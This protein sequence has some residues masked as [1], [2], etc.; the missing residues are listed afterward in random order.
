MAEAAVNQNKE[1]DVF[2]GSS[3]MAHLCRAVDWSAT[4]LGPVE[5]WPEALRTVVRT[6]LE[7]PFPTNLWCGPD[8]LLIYN[9]GYRRVLGAKHPRALGRAGAEVWREIWPDIQPMFDSVRR[10][11]PV[12]MEDARFVMERQSGPPGEAWF[13]FSLS[14][15]RDADG[16]IVAFLNVAT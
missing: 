1:H 6:V 5:E 15:V 3:E 7:S 2:I 4:S 8:L 9:D 16:E 11:S 14:G 12:Y 10:G 13:T